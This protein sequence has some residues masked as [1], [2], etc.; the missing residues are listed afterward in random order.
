M[1]NSSYAR[2]MKEAY[3]FGPIAALGV[4]GVGDVGELMPGE[5][6]EDR[7]CG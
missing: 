6:R 1:G 2:V 3:L 4:V 7:R 5:G